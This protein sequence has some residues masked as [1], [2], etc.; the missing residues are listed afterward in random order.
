MRITA[1]SV[2]L[3]VTFRVTLSAMSRSVTPFR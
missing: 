2:W 3:Y 1:L